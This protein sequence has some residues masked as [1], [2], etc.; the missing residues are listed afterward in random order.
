MQIHAFDSKKQLTL[1]SQ[2]VK[3]QDYFCFECQSIVRLRAGLHRQPHFYHI[4]QQSSC[5]QSGKSLAH[6]QVQLYLQKI[7]PQEEAVMEHRFPEINRIA[8]LVWHSEKLIFE[9]QCSPISAEEV[10]MRNRDY[11]SLGYQV[12]WILHDQTFNQPRVSAAEEYLR[13]KPH[14]FTDMDR[15][16]QGIIYDQF[17]WI[18]N[19]RRKKVLPP[20]K[21]N[22]NEPRRKSALSTLGSP[23]LLNRLENWSIGFSGDLFSLEGEDS[24]LKQM[25]EIE[26][27]KNRLQLE[28]WLERFL[29]RP[30]RLFLRYL[31]EKACR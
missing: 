20:L 12:I 25:E 14:Y 24:Y 6:L 8:D 27:N 28:E 26:S 1:A 18:E 9:V 15:E 23:F 2:A 11:A 17:E 4:F 3:K 31:L 5:R 10:N 16:G 7:L 21:I 30:Y 19:S 22:L 29:F 13:D